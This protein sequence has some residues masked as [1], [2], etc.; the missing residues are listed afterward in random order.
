MGTAAVVLC[1]YTFIAMRGQHLSMA[2]KG[3]LPQVASCVL[4]KRSWGCAMS[5]YGFQSGQDSLILSQVYEG[6]TVYDVT[7]RRIGAVEY[8]YL[9]ELTMAAD[10]YGQGWATTSADGNSEG[11]LIQEFARALLLTEQVPDAWREQFMCYGFFKVNSFSFLT[12]GR[13][14]LPDQIASVVNN[15][16]MLRV[17]RDE[18]PKF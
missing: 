16:V 3:P 1:C 15:N 17:C 13:Y 14:V 4:D 8:V 18:L 2:T 6:M 11:S 5:Q 9:G 10:E 12:A 7:G